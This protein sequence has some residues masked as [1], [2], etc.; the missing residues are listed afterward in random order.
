MLS[1]HYVLTNIVEAC[2]RG[3]PKSLML[4]ESSSKHAESG[5]NQPWPNMRKGYLMPPE[6]ENR[7]KSRY[8]NRNETFLSS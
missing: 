7:T 1:V 6:D 4:I 5:T 3:L 2:L 8:S